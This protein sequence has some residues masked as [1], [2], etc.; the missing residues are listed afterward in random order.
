MITYIIQ[1][2][3]W[4]V[5][6][7]LPQEVQQ[8]VNYSEEEYF[9][10]HSVP[11][12]SYMSEM[13]VD[14]TVVQIWGL[15]RERINKTNVN[16]IGAELGKVSEEDISCSIEFN[17]PVARVR[18]LL[19]IKERLTKDL[20]VMLETGTSVH[21]KFKYEKL[22]LFCYFCGV[23]GH[24]HYACRII[25][26]H[27]YELIKC[28]GSSKDVKPNFTS[29]MKASKFFNGI[30]CERKQVVSFSGQPRQ[31]RFNEIPGPALG[32]YFGKGRASATR[33][34]LGE[35]KSSLASRQNQKIAV[36]DS[37][38]GAHNMGTSGSTTVKSTEVHME[39]ESSS[40]NSEMNGP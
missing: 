25:A 12:E 1:S 40:R 30:A 13:E 19:D 28:G 31:P 16:I 9:K 11:L 33:G 22:D 35:E 8:K 6:A 15:P 24:D 17:K 23:I 4:K 37:V 29:M 34:P 10:N 3:R 38:R 36:E 26:H 20:T 39:V 5:G 18:V 32:R 27:G 14:L 21:V 7:V 2:F